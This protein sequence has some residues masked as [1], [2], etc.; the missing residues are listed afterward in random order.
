MERILAAWEETGWVPEPDAKRLFA[1]AGFDV[2]RF[3]WA[4]TPGEACR[5]AAET[6]Y[7]VVA[8]V[9]SPRIMHKSDVG[10]VEVGIANDEQLRAAFDRFSA[11]DGFEGMVVDETISGAE[12][13]VGATVDA[14]FGP[15]VLLG[16]GGI[17]VELYRDTA[18]RMAPIEQKDVLSMMN[19]LTAHRLFEGFR[20]SE[21]VDI[22]ILS[23]LVVNFS[24]LAM[25]LESRIESIDLNPV[26]CTSKRCVIAD[27][28]IILT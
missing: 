28:R 20:G 26:M 2:P 17:G 6:G 12:L 16:A 27:A 21:P 9:V 10:G 4:K 22:G 7:P 23:S 24:H 1:L 19:S 3:T 11:L 14:Q 15:V 8:K 18:I 13:I 5:F 25:A